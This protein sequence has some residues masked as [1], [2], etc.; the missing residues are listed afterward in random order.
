MISQ[1]F[2]GTQTTYS[3]TTSTDTLRKHLKKHHAQKYQ[4]ACEQHGWKYLLPKEPTIGEN[5]KGRLPAFS[6]ETFLEYLVRFVTADD[7]VR[8]APSS[9]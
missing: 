7:Q 8:V 5:R 6:P 2:S 3:L 9:P 4:E 1:R